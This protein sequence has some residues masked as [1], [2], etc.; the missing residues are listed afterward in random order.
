MDVVE[1]HQQKLGVALQLLLILLGLSLEDRD[2]GAFCVPPE[3]A[4]WHSGEAYFFCHH[5]QE[6][7]KHFV[8]NS[9]DTLHHP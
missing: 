3:G 6:G 9:D 1:V 4:C 5:V 8:S 2:H 7:I